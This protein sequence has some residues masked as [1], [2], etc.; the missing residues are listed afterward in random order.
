M[1]FDDGRGNVRNNFAF[2]NFLIEKI[3]NDACS[4]GESVTG[5]GLLI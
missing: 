2:I 4:A 3:S 5:L 1:S